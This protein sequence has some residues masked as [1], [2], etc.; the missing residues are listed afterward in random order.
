MA[1]PTKVTTKRARI[2]ADTH[3]TDARLREIAEI[4]A[5][6]SSQTR[7]NDPEQWA[8]VTAWFK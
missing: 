4:A 7:R 6:T 1:K 3:Y 2:H 8:R 5:I